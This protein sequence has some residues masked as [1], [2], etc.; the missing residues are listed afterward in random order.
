MI[1]NQREAPVVKYIFDSV[2]SG[3]STTQITELLRQY[4]IPTRKGGKWSNTTVRNI[5]SNEKY[6]GDALLQKTYTDSEFRRHRNNGEVQSY[7]INDHHPPI[8]SHEVFEKA[9]ALVRQRAKEKGLK[10]GD[11][12]YQQRY[13]FS[14]IIICSCCGSRFKRRIHNNGKEIAWACSTHIDN[15]QKCPMQYIRDDRIKTAF[16]TM[17]NKLIYSRKL[18]LKPLLNNIKAN[19]ND[20]N[21][22]RIRELQGYIE[23]NTEKKN[24]LR[25]LRSREIIDNVVYNQELNKLSS[26][27]ENYR[28]E[29]NT[30]NQFTSG[31]AIMI[32]ELES[33]IRLVENTSFISE[34]NDDMF[35]SVVDNIIVYDRSHIGVKL[36]CGLTL[37]EEI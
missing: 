29:L 23:A 33:L 13:S 21:V 11:S 26:E 8:I 4:N 16:A 24:T 32:S 2:I 27:S 10:P 12:K 36:K 9:N 19:S 14:G 5:I 7:L 28:N 20:D 15:I 22:A 31:E 1:I 37:K 30:L 34:F 6:T 17:I 18:V 35:I 3:L 25:M